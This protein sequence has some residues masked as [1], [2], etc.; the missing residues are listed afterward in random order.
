M[1]IDETITT[2]QLFSNKVIPVGTTVKGKVIDFRGL[3]NT[4]NL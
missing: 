4:G 2:T 1:S 3:S